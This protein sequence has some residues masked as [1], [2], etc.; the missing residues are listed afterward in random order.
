VPTAIG[1]EAFHPR[2]A[3]AE[4]KKAERPR[5]NVTATEKLVHRAYQHL[6]AGDERF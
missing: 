3:R 1:E 2:S 6:R 5:T 4:G